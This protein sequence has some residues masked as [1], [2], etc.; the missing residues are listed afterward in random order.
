M[1][2]D[3]DAIN[4]PDEAGDSVPDPEDIDWGPRQEPLEEGEPCPE[5]GY[6]FDSDEWNIR[7]L[8]S[9]PTL[10]QT[11]V[12]TCPDCEQRTYKVGT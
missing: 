7:K 5:C 4:P 9:G 3:F 10:G 8:P 1:S 11:W 2:D 6:E 12:G